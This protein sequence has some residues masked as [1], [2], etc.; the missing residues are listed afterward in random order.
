MVARAVRSLVAAAIFMCAGAPSAWGQAGVGT[1]IT[2][3]GVVKAGGSPLNGTADLQFRLYPAATGGTQV[4]PT[5]A[6]N[7]LTITGGEFTAALDFGSG[8]FTGQALWLEIDVRSPAGGGSFTTLTRQAMT[9]APYALFALSGNEGP[10]GPAGPTGATGPQGPQGATGAQG[11]QGATGPQGPQGP[12]GATGAQGPQ[13]PEGPQGPAG[14]SPWSLNGTITY[15]TAGRVGVGTNAPSP[16]AQLD[17]E[18]Q[19]GGAFGIETT[20]FLAGI[21]GYSTQTVGD[22]SGGNFFSVSTSGKGVQGAATTASG[23]NF[24]GYFTSA[25]PAGTGVFGHVTATTGVGVGVGGRFQSDMIG[26]RGVWG[27]ASHTAAGGYGGF[28]QT[29]S[30]NGTGVAGFASASIAATNYGGSFQANGAT[31]RGVYGYA[32]HTSGQNYG[33]YF[34]TDST[35]G[36]AVFGIADGMFPGARY[37]GVFQTTGVDASMGVSGM[38]TSNAAGISFGGSFESRAVD[39]RGVLGWAS[40]TSAGQNYGGF[41]DAR[42]TNG[43]GVY[44]Q[45]TS[46]SGVTTGGSLRCDSASSGAR[47][48]FAF[49]SATSGATYAGQ[50]R[51]DS[52]GGRAVFAQA[53]ANAGVTAGGYFTAQSPTGEG[54]VGLNIANSGNAYGG[55]FASSSPTGRGVYA[56]AGTVGG[57]V[58]YGVYGEAPAAGYA[59]WAQGRTGA[60]GTKSFRIDHPADPANKYLHHYSSEGPVPQNI[61]NGIAEFDASGEAVVTLPGYFASINKDARYLL[62]AM[63][64]PMPMLHVAAEIDPGDPVAAFRIAGGVPGARVSW[65]VKATRN[66][67]WVRTYGAPIEEDK[68]ASERGRYLEPAL[69][70][71]GREAGLNP[72]GADV[73]MPD[74]KPIP[75]IPL[76][77]PP[78]P[79]SRAEDRPPAAD[80]STN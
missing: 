61:Y 32:A 37:G 67:R 33:G 21:V 31:G 75:E 57:M 51:N 48:L 53:V 17:V 4:G 59:L 18:V 20:G 40:N 49:C 76:Q 45:A 55:R 9:A 71:L 77:L 15:Y 23:A 74:V 52:S 34:E 2:Y 62:T 30:S 73:H 42:G 50:F 6:A 13:G 66:D 68:P 1:T 22:A 24:G 65:E 27:W 78:A 46:A 10:Q 26:G 64:A 16:S 35:L 25:S 14:A 79:A 58:N 69:Y 44:A 36:T 80:G 43:V 8:V 38:A 3:Q 5:L 39:G 47:A 72:A 63:G 28:F 70:G 56:L 41:F 7:G 19:S 54:C 12:Q 11:P 60:S 29:D